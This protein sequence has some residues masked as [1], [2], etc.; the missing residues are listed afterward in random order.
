MV[1]LKLFLQ[2]RLIVTNACDAWQYFKCAGF[3]PAVE[4]SFYCIECK[5]CKKDF[6]K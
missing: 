1:I 4:T 5:K 3:R 2:C 6:V